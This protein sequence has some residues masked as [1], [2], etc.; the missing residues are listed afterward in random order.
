M[1]VQKVSSFPPVSPTARVRAAEIAVAAALASAAAWLFLEGG[2]RG[3]SLPF[4]LAWV[5]AH[6]LYGAARG[7]FWALPIAA[8]CP[9]LFVVAGSGSWLEATFVELFHGILFTFAGVVARRLWRARR[10]RELSRETGGED[11]V[12]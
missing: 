12:A 10:P 11:F 1:F 8:T 3:C 2:E 4:F 9:P 6:V 5:A 7:S